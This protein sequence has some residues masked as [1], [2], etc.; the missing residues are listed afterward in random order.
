M[1][2]VQFY[3]AYPN[4]VCC[5]PVLMGEASMES[6]AVLRDFHSQFGSPVGAVDPQLLGEQPDARLQHRKTLGQE[7][8]PT[9]YDL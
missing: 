8:R 7:R 5:F 2:E 1:G 3:G 6:A 9:R 4:V